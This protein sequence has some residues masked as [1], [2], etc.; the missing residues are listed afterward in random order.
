M[1]NREMLFFT[2][3]PIMG[4]RFALR[5]FFAD[6]ILKIMRGFPEKY[7]IVAQEIMIVQVKIKILQEYYIRNGEKQAENQLWA[8]VQ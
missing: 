6:L 1:N 3:I 4:A 2:H 8:E 7:V 5:E